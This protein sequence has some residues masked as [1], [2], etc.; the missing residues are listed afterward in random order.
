[1]STILLPD[2]PAPRI[3]TP[4]P[5]TKG[6]DLIPILGGVDIAYNRVGDKWAVTFDLPPMTHERATVWGARLAR[7]R[8]GSVRMRIPQPGISIRG[9][10]GSVTVNGASQA[11][12]TLNVENGR[13][14]FLLREGQWITVETGGRGFLYNIGE[15]VRF[16]A[17]GTAALSIDPMIRRSPA[18][19]D[20]VEILNPYIEGRLEGREAG[21]TLDV[22][23]TNGLSFTIVERE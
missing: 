4:R 6:S 12:S 20:S 17:G 22:A 11:G 21:W 3:F 13:Q 7:G 5:V 15:E 9:N 8:N 16:G 18:D 1:M 2:R 23:M 14:N 19:G 10:P